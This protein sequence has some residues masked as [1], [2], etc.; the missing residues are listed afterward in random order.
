MLSHETSS[1]TYAHAPEMRDDPL[2]CCLDTQPIRVLAS[3]FT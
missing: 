3:A 2:S 1:A